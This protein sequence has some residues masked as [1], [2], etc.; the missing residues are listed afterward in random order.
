[1]ILEWFQ[2]TKD[3]SFFQKPILRVNIMLYLPENVLFVVKSGNLGRKLNIYK[4]FRTNPGRF[5]KD[6]C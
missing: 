5:R 4:T 6:C 1:M 2:T 3:A